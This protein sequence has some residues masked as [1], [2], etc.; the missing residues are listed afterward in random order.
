MIGLI[1]GSA[2]GSS[3]GETH[4]M[5]LLSAVVAGLVGW[6]NGY[7]YDFMERGIFAAIHRALPAI[8]ILGAVGMVIGSWMAGGVVPAM[9]YYGLAIMK[10]S[11]FYLAVCLITGIVALATGSSWTAA[12]TI[13]VAFIG[14]AQGMDMSLAIT[15]GAIISGAYFGDKMSPFSDSCNIAAA[16]AEVNIF[17]HIRHMMY[18]VIPAL[19]IALVLYGIIG[20]G[21]VDQVADSETVDAIRRGLDENFNMTPLLFLPAV[22]TLALI[23]MKVPAIPGLLAGALLGCLSAVVFQGVFVGDLPVVLHYGFTFE[24]AE[25]VMPQLIDLCERGGLDSMLWTIS[26]LMCAMCLGGVMECTGMLVVLAE[27]LLKIAKTTGLLVLVTS[28]SC[29]FMNM[30]AGDSCLTSIIVG[31]MYK[32][33]FENRRLKTKNLSRILENVG[34]VTAPLIPWNSCGATMYAFLGVPNMAFLPFAFLNLTTPIIAVLFGFTGIT[35]SKMTEEEYQA[36]LKAREEEK[37]S[38][39]G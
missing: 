26:L 5:L 20:F 27:N 35:M 36:V 28:I 13:G 1:F 10:P 32:E 14:I 29:I 34:T 11:I 31:K 30:I 3:Y 7:K 21:N 23:I 8:V 16:I 22:I 9:I 38:L 6:K 17:E 12:G 33:E 4:I 37:K 18:S 19:I 15:A 39:E 2:F 25:N 24:N